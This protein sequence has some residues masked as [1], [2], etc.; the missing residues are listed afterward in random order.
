[1][2]GVA[3]ISLSRS[4]SL[5][6]QQNYSGTRSHLD[7]SDAE[8]M[9]AKLSP[10][11]QSPE[12]ESPEV[13]KKTPNL[14]SVPGAQA[15]TSTEPTHQQPTQQQ[16]LL[17]STLRDRLLASP[18]KTRHLLTNS[19]NI[20]IVQ[21][22]KL[23][24]VN[25]TQDSAEN[26][27]GCDKQR[28]EDATGSKPKRK[29]ASESESKS[30]KV[31]D[32]KIGESAPRHHKTSSSSDLSRKSNDKS[33]NTQ[34]KVCK[35][36]SGCRGRIATAQRKPPPPNVENFL[37]LD[38]PM[39]RS[40]VLIGPPGI[41][42]QKHY[43]TSSHTKTLP[44]LKHS[45]TGNPMYGVSDM[46]VPYVTNFNSLPRQSSY[47]TFSSQPNILSNERLITGPEYRSVNK[48]NSCK[49]VD[50]K[51]SDG[52]HEYQNVDGKYFP[53]K[54]KVRTQSVGSK[55]PSFHRTKPGDIISRVAYPPTAPIQNYIERHSSQL[56]KSS[57]QLEKSQIRYPGSIPSDLR[58]HTEST[59]L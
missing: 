35:P 33:T 54:P 43:F 18:S 50:T 23:E 34:S 11:Q 6:R 10:L 31:E 27:S 32:L 22:I 2:S 12:S 20:S 24:R 17:Q 46:R 42:P 49:N 36:G 26:S 40:S 47:I 38:N 59:M 48:K 14:L 25:E 51:H 58:G 4:N 29:S 13:F 16:Q 15:S 7:V 45:S 21:S 56:E 55:E 28:R 5:N 19:P 1:M 30:S 39:Y 44:K 37:P 3:G 57:S 53:S 9:A 52:G 41:D 8:R